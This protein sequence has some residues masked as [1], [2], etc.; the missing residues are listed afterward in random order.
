M[1]YAVVL[2]DIQQEVGSDGA[3]STHKLMSQHTGPEGLG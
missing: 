2:L 1:I 3:E